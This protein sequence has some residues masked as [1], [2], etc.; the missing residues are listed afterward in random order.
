MIV[1]AVPAS[2]RLWQLEQRVTKVCLPASVPAA[3]EVVA[4]AGDGQAGEREGERGREAA[5]AE[6]RGGAH[7]R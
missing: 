7:M 3:S 6:L 5:G 2:W 1:G 4:A